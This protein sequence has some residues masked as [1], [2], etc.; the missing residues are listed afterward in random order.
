VQAKEL[1]FYYFTLRD[2]LRIESYYERSLDFDE[3][4][5]RLDNLEYYIEKIEGVRR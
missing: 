1:E 5:I 2:N 4:Q 3:V